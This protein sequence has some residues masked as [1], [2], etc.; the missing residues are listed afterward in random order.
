MFSFVTSSAGAATS[1]S[2]EPTIAPICSG[3]GMPVNAVRARPPA[4]FQPVDAA[5]H[6]FDGYSRFSQRWTLLD[7]ACDN[8]LDQGDLRIFETLEAPSIELQA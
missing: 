6:V 3:V 8:P 5:E 1:F 2:S 7:Q 4:R